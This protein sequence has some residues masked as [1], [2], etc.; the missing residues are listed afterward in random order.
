[1]TDPYSFDIDRLDPRYGTVL[2]DL[3]GVVH[4][5]HHVFPGAA[6]RLARW[7]REGRTVVLITNAPRPTAVIQAQLDRLG[8]DRTSYR[9]ISTGGQAGIDALRALGRPVGYLGPLLDRRDLEEAGVTLVASDFRDVAVTGLDE[10]RPAII[11]YAEQLAAFAAADVLFHCLNPDRIVIHG[12]RAELC[13]G[14]LADA[15]E[16]VGGSVCWYGKP[17]PAIYDHALRAA[18]SPARHQ[19]LAVGDGLLTDVLGAARQGIDCLFVSGGIHG[20]KPIPPDFAAE[21]GLGDWS[22][23]GVVKSIA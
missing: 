5:G 18:G 15:Y 22:P 16:A 13:A 12:G 8:L 3:W 20:G 21:H 1:M 14:S 6:E 11:D 2:C 7:T 10:H 4:D 23:A 19:V 9:A 17:W